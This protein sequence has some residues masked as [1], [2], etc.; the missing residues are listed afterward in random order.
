MSWA[1]AASYCKHEQI[2][3]TQNQ[4]FGHHEHQ[5]DVD[6]PPFVEPADEQAAASF[7]ED[8]ASCHMGCAQPLPVEGLYSGLQASA[9]QVPAL[10]SL[11]DSHVPSGLDRPDIRIA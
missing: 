9:P 1:A 4:H 7:D 11:H 5:H 10:T 6:A 3:S 2:T 8:C